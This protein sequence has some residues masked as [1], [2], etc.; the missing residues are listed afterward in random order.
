MKTPQ[1]L[2]SEK[3]NAAAPFSQRIGE[4]LDWLKDRG[5]VLGKHTAVF[6]P[7]VRYQFV[8][9]SSHTNCWR[10]EDAESLSLSGLRAHHYND[11]NK[12]RTAVV[13]LEEERKQEAED[14][15]VFVPLHY[16]TEKLLAEFFEIDLN[17]VEKEKQ[18]L[19]ELLRKGQL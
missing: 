2:E 8:D 13:L 14:N 15:P 4:F 16:S 3:V 6:D 12:V 17:K 7:P 10:I 1:M 18:A 5:I 11:L 19:L 9:C